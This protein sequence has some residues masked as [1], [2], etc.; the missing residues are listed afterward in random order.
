MKTHTTR[1]AILIGLSLLAVLA[2]APAEAHVH[3]SPN[4]NCSGGVSP[5]NVPG[6]SHASV[7]GTNI[8]VQ[9]IVGPPVGTNTGV[10]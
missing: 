2:A 6:I 9:L 8:C 3:V 7:C 5:G 10:C 4:N 1:V